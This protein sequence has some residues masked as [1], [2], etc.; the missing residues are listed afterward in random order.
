VAHLRR[1]PGLSGRLVFEVK[2][3]GRWMGAGVLNIAL[4]LLLL[5]PLAL[6]D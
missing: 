3:L 5:L 1:C 6:A 2:C 4:L